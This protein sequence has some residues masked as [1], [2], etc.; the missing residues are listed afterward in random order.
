MVYLLHR[1]AG[2]DAQSF[3]QYW[4]DVHAPLAA[5]LPGLRRYVQ[6]YPNFD[7]VESR[8]PFDGIAEIW[9]DSRASMELAFG[10]PQ[11]Q[12]TMADVPHFLDEERLQGFAVEEVT[13]V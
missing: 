7:S 10:S 3:V 8:A 9:F 11:G 4:R 12:A 13:I 6:N 5:N 1:R 2:M